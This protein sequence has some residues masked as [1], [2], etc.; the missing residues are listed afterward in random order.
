MKP[1]LMISSFN[2]Y[3]TKLNQ[4]N[5]KPIHK[6]QILCEYNFKINQNHQKIKKI[7][8]NLYWKS[9]DKFIK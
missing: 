1:N 2:N 9:G 6:S 5:K 7:F 3:Y 8:N 4:G